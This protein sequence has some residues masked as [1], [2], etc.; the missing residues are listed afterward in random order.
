[1]PD[2]FHST[3]FLTLPEHEHATVL[4]PFATGL[5]SVDA[6][7]L[8]NGVHCVFFCYLPSTATPP[9]LSALASTC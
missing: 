5:L 2:V 7:I 8:S 9:I 1:M 3:Q 6:T 4:V